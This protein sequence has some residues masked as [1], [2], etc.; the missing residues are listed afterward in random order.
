MNVDR[1]IT[2]IEKRYLLFKFSGYF[3][4]HI[5]GKTVQSE[6][7]AVQILAEDFNIEVL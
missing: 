3:Y 7:D 5:D 4:L 1:K 6:K 2:K